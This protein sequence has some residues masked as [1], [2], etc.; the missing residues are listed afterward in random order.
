MTKSKVGAEPKD[1]VKHVFT[2]DGGI[3]EGI[4]R[5]EPGWYNSNYHCYCFGYGYF[6]HRGK[7]LGE[8]LTPDYIRD[9][10]DKAWWCGGLKESC[11][12]R[13]DRKR[14]IAVIK[15][16]TEYAWK[17]EHGLPQG[18][19]IYKTD[20]FLLFMQLPCITIEEKD[21]NFVICEKD[22]GYIPHLYCYE[23]Q[24]VIDWIDDEGDSIKCING[25]TPDQAIRKAFKW[26]VENR[27][28]SINQLISYDRK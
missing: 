12:A 14:K 28:I 23:D 4:H 5:D 19:I 24:Y 3:H 18:Y 26:C 7:S 2:K 6:F 25:I 1:R 10:W 27:L 15:E 21:D 13:I 22:C 16:G 20:E 8:K 17:I 11:M 9:N